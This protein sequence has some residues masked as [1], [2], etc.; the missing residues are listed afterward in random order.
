MDLRCSIAAD[1]HRMTGKGPCSN[2]K[3]DAY[4]TNLLVFARPIHA[5]WYVLLARVD[6]IIPLS[7]RAPS[8]QETLQA[9]Q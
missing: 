1:F 4:L 5:K 6:M 2:S 3:Q 8:P 9:S 7:P